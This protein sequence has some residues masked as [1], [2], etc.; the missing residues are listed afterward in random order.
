LDNPPAIFHD[1]YEV[2]SELG[3][4]TTGT[5]YEARDTRLNVRVAIRVPN[6]APDSERLAKTRRFVSECRALAFLTG[7]TTCNIPR[8]HAVEEHPPGRFYSV[9]ELVDGSTLEQR[10]ADGSID[11]RTGLCIVAGVAR[12]V[13]SVHERGFAHRNI[14]P[15]NVLVA[16]DITPWLI[17]FGRVG[18]LAGS[19]LLAAGATG[20][21]VEVDVQGLRELL[22]W[23]C[24]ALRCPVPDSL[25]LLNAAGSALTAGAFSDAV[26][27]HL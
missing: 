18:L 12:V 22:R 6:L 11:L 10:V 25:E 15:T 24:G 8:L 13:Q 16:R 19:Q 7:G 9:R 21:P 5:V 23:L 4:G 17:G 26:A 1:F 20:T 2:V 3:H 14:S 27:S